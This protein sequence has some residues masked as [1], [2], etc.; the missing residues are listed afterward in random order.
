M[1]K[2]IV[3]L[4][5][6]IFTGHLLYAQTQVPVLQ[7]D[8][9]NIIVRYKDITLNWLLEPNKKPD[10][11]HLGS[12]LKPQYVQF[13]TNKDSMNFA[14]EAG[15][16]IDFLIVLKG[17][18]NCY[19]QIDALANPFFFKSTFGILLLVLIILLS[20]FF[21][22][23]HN[24]FSINQLLSLGW[25]VPV[26]FWITTIIAGFLHGNYNHL[27]LAVSELGTIGT[28]A[29]V[30]MSVATLLLGVFSIFFSIGFCKASKKLGISLIPAVLSFSM[31]ISFAWAAVFPSGHE[32]HGLFGPFPILVMAG[33][34]WAALLWR[35]DKTY[36]RVRVYSLAGFLLMSLFL[37]R[38]NQHLQ[39]N[40]EGLIQRFL[41]AGWSV[42][43]I[44][45]SIELKKMGKSNNKTPI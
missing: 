17:K 45:L 15:N 32:L 36:L 10:I 7:S 29:E 9:A 27:K 19:V 22:W 38:F 8:T 12:S 5:V 2:L 18:E 11:L 1:R 31:A 26:A 14:I 24:Y 30:F 42:W 43:F 34:L 28:G 44:A 3:L 13:I 4:V 6:L 41:W 37:L 25:M 20:T 23:K 33:A 39:Q 35:K 21:I 40:F 16:K